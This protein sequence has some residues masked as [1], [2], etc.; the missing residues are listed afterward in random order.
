MVA[1]VLNKSPKPDSGFKFGLEFREHSVQEPQA[2]ESLVKIQAAA[3]NHRDVWILKG[4]Y[5][6]ISPE[7]VMGADAVG[8]VV[9]N[10]PSAS[11]EVG[12]RVLLNPGRGWESDERGPEGAFRILGLLPCVGKAV[13]TK[14]QVKEG[15]HVLI[16]GIGGGVAL[17]ALQLAVAA[18]AHVYVTSSSPEK[19]QRAISL[20]AKGGV[21]YK[22][23][24]VITKDQ[25]KGVF[26]DKDQIYVLAN[27]IADL[28][29]LLG[30]NLL[31]AVIDGAG[32]PLYAQYP[33]V[34]RPGG[35]IA[36]YGQTGGVQGVTYSMGHVMKHI[37]LCA[38][39]MGSRKEFQDM[40]A[41][42]ERHKIRPVVSQVWQGLNEKSIEEAIGVM[43]RGEQFG[44][45]V[46]EINGSCSPRLSQKL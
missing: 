9:Q 22:D 31:S 18:K 40:V 38:C 13:F 5:P 14:A 42:V 15:E 43:R 20:G 39:T 23:G 37:D 24:I 26:S 3:L 35:I 10:G 36:N 28:K 6:G 25:G 12:Q 4:M 11:V 45:L 16:T 30:N 34:M 29:K 44:K 46:I 32:G 27:C 1:V 17:M 2:T 21:N 8:I 7:S 41:F 19:I 33:K